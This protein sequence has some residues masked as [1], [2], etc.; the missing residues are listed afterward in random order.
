MMEASYNI[1]LMYAIEHVMVTLHSLIIHN[2]L[3]RHDSAPLDRY[4]K[5]V[6]TC[7]H[8]QPQTTAAVSL[9]LA[10]NIAD[11]VYWYR[12]TEGADKSLPISCASLISVL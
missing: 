8:L 5:A 7:K 12:Q 4:A 3:L 9:S 6:A 1:L 11:N 2:T 10:A